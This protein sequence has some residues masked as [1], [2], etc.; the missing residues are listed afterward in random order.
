MVC[1]ISS[2]LLSLLS[3]CRTAFVDS[4]WD[5]VIQWLDSFST[6][7]NALLMLLFILE[8][9]PS[10]LTEPLFTRLISISPI[11]SSFPALL[12]FFS[13]LT[14]WNEARI[15]SFYH[16]VQC[17]S[18]SAWAAWMLGVSV[19]LCRGVSPIRKELLTK[20]TSSAYPLLQSIIGSNS[21]SSRRSSNDLDLSVLCGDSSLFDPSSPFAPSCLSS[22]FASVPAIQQIQPSLLPLLFLVACELTKPRVAESLRFLGFSTVYRFVSQYE[23]DDRAMLRGKMLLLNG[24]NYES[25]LNRSEVC[26]MMC[27]LALNHLNQL[28]KEERIESILTKNRSVNQKWMISSVS[29]IREISNG[30]S[31]LI[32]EKSP[33]FQK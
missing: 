10:R 18:E 21:N 33:E 17:R 6:N 28:K 19:L 2:L 13:V 1:F 27:N 15:C 8:I 3:H 23:M 30:W 16:S 14:S 12:S 31:N 32:T 11:S 22:L 24:S 4:D 9:Q 7:S 25:K 29:Q 26:V 20:I 5:E